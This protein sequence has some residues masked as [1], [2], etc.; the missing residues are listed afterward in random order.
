MENTKIVNAGQ[1]P[2]PVW[3][4]EAGERY[5]TTNVVVWGGGP[6]AVPHND[7]EDAKVLEQG[8]QMGHQCF[9]LNEHYSPVGRGLLGT[10]RPACGADENNDGDPTGY[11]DA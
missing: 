3:G 9:L 11:G 10:H 7:G 1:R 4:P 6:S 2:V 5:I 8:G